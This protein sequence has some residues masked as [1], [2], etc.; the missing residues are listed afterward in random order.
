MAANTHRGFQDVRHATNQ[1]ILGNSLH[2]FKGSDEEKIVQNFFKVILTD[3]GFV[4]FFNLEIRNCNAEDGTSFRDA[5]ISLRATYECMMRARANFVTERPSCEG[6]EI[7]DLLNTDSLEDFLSRGVDAIGISTQ[8]DV[9]QSFWALL[10]FL[11]EIKT[12]EGAIRRLL[13]IAPRNTSKK[14]QI[15]IGL[16]HH[17]FSKL[18]PNKK[19][20]VDENIKNLPQTCGCEDTLKTNGS[21]SLIYDACG[22]YFDDGN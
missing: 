1:L 14:T 15:M 11:R 6:V 21:V 12:H 17:L 22:P 7:R 13:N 16:A 3:P 4:R 2:D 20:E 19:Y 8:P 18:V 5:Y 10:N 9:C